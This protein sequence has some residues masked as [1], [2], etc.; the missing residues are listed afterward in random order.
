MAVDQEDAPKAP[1]N[2]EIKEGGEPEP[3]REKIRTGPGLFSRAFGVVGIVIS[4]G[5]IWAFLWGLKFSNEFLAPETE[6][7]EL[8]VTIPE[9]AA[10]PRIGQ[11]L[12]EAG[13]IKSAEAFGWALKIK[14]RLNRGKPIV[15]K[16]GELAL[17]PSLPVW[18]IIDLAAKGNY[19][20]YPFTVPEGKN[21]FEIAKMVEAAGLGSAEDFLDLCRDRQFINSLGLS[22]KNL[23][24]YLFP[25][26]YNFPKGTPLKTVIKTMTDSFFNI[27]KKYDSQSREAGLTRHE[28]IT[29]ASI[30]EKETGAAPERPIISGVFHNRLKKGM[31]LQTDPTVVYGLTNFSGSIT[32]RDLAAEHPYNTYI[33]PALPPGPIANPGEAAIA[34]A[35]KPATVS[36]LYFV[37][38]N[39][40]THQFSN[41]L[42]EHNRAVRQYQR[43]GK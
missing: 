21:M 28:A 37:S 18:E 41:T 30:V 43:G 20:L 34:A 40:G 6:S 27:W 4:L 36:Y 33:I 14:N 42:N 7:R 19:K 23:E 5:L 35:V 13:A 31:R 9:G 32:Q 12:E 29:L 38:K 10:A 26:T 11:I 39:D 15:L 25:E 16:A 8:V 24:G 3:R 2:T 22:E 1:E 17:D